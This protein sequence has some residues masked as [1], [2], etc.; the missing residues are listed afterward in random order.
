[1]HDILLSELYDHAVKNETIYDIG[2]YHGVYT[3]ALASKGCLVYAF[4]P[5]PNSYE[6]LLTNVNLNGF[7]NVKAFNIGLSDHRNMLEFFVSSDPGRSSFHRFNATYG[8]NKIVSIKR[9]D[10]DTLDNLIEEKRIVPPNHIKIDVE[11]HE[12]KILR[13]GKAT[14]M[15]YRPM[16]WLEI[17]ETSYGNY[18]VDKLNQILSSM[19]YQITKYGDKWICAPL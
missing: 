3:L 17:H 2:A 1:M 7:K 18:R 9:I 11:G 10:V 15:K 19:E 4:E 14:I 8:G 16:I 5:N 6:K 13:G 12:L